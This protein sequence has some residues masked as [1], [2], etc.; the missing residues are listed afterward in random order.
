M[1]NGRIVFDETFFAVIL[2]GIKS[3]YLYVVKFP[4]LGSI[5]RFANIEPTSQNHR[6]NFFPHKITR[7]DLY[8]Y[9]NNDRPTPN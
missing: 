4:V 2:G 3:M 8:D 9:V 7:Y 5:K 6:I 1:L